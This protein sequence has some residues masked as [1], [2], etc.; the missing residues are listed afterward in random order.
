MDGV[1]TVLEEVKTLAKN[2]VSVEDF[3]T[4][5]EELKGNIEK[6]N[7]DIE[8]DL[9][10]KYGDIDDRVKQASKDFEDKLTNAVK[11]M[12]KAF[13]HN[14]GQKENA[15][16]PKIYGKSFGEFLSKVKFKPSELK[17]LSENTGSLG[18]YL[19][20]DAWSNQILKR[21]I[22]GSVVRNVGARTITLPTPQFNIPAIKST[23]NSGSVYGGIITYWGEESSNLESNKT[24]PTFQKI[25]LD[26][27]KLF[28]YTESYEDL[29]MDS[30]TAIGPLLQELFS[31]AIMFEED[32]QFLQVMELINL[33][34]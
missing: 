29:N 32:C 15:P 6:R 10:K 34:V 2:K 33:W 13:K 24:T 16:D 30:I 18:G 14:A 21:I 9:N 4:K 7:K 31:D 1:Q 12:G 28:G 5:V 8:T 22:E 3:T 27:Q 26:A 17:T 19:V 20:P 11:E 25:S 23:N